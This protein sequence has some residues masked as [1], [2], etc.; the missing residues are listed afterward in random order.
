MPFSNPWL[1]RIFP[2]GQVA[3]FQCEK[4]SLLTLRMRL[5]FSIMHHIC[6]CKILMHPHTDNIVFIVIVQYGIP[7]TWILHF[8]IAL[9]SDEGV[10]EVYSETICL[11]MKVPSCRRYNSYP[12]GLNPAYLRYFSVH[13]NQLLTDTVCG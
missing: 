3:Y 1:G 4:R 9:M 12:Y 8:C 6:C 10:T 13:V 5:F 2:F 11:S 7:F